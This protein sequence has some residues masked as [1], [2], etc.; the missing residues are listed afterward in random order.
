MKKTYTLVSKET[1]RIKLITSDES[2]N[3]D[4]R[5]FEIRF[6]T[7]V[8]KNRISKKSMIKPFYYR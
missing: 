5:L 2:Y 4:T 8:G 7:P 6:E 1:R 3:Y